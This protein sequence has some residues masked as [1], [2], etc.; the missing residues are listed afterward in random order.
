[1]YGLYMVTNGIEGVISQDFPWL[2]REG[3]RVVFHSRRTLKLYFAIGP[4][5]SSGSAPVVS[6]NQSNDFRYRH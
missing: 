6:F 2:G 5:F 4:T 3:A 1:M